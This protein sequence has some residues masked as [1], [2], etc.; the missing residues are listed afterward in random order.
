MEEITQPAAQIHIRHLSGRNPVSGQFA[1]SMLA[2]FRQALTEGS[3]ALQQHGCTL[4][5]V[6]RIVCT[7]DGTQDFSSCFTTLNEPVSYTHLTLPTILLV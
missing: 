7:V 4:H 1:S 6:T 5:D 2:Q 3:S